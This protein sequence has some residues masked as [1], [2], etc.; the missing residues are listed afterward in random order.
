METFKSVALRQQDGSFENAEPAPAKTYE[1]MFNHYKAKKE[2]LAKVR[3][4]Y[5]SLI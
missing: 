3:L 4:D 1:D 2:I 5:L